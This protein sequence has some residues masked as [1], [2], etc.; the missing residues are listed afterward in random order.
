M[1]IFVIDDE[2]AMVDLLVR[3]CR[4]GGHDVLGFTSS[5]RAIETLTTT[6]VDLVITDL[7]MP[8]PDGLAVLR[9]MRRLQAD[10]MALAITG[11]AAETTLE[12]VL[13]AGASDLLF[14]PL[15]L[16]E[17]RIRVQLAAGRKRA[18]EALHDQR[19]ALH[20]VSAEMISGLQEELARARAGSERADAPA[21]HAVDPKTR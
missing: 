6:K 13:S 12:Q 19:R 2:P 17:V 10:A 5:E 15:R 20:A 21:S 18:F 11:H 3:T 7:M 1:R 4:A 9:E 8:A 16:E 14:K